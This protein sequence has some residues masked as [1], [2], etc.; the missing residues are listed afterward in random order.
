[1]ARL[2]AEHRARL[3]ELAK[4]VS[5]PAGTRIFEEGGTADRFWVIRTGSVTLDMHVPG[6]RA[7][8]MET[9][10]PGELL[11]WSWL[12]PPRTW[13]QGAEALSPVRALEFDADAVQRMCREDPVLGHSLVL[14]V[15]EVIGHRLKAARARLQGV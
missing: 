9:I 1:M 15:A 8:T 5:F 10:G 12:F 6:R 3:M 14:A 13:H 7:A 4:E 2:S 11:G